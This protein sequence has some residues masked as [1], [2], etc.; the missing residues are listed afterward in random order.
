[1]SPTIPKEERER[2]ERVA[3]SSNGAMLEHWMREAH[4]ALDE[5]EV[6]RDEYREK[7]RHECSRGCPHWGH[8]TSNGVE[9]VCWHG[10]PDHFNRWLAEK[11]KIEERAEKAEADVAAVREQLAKASRAMNE[12]T[13]AADDAQRIATAAVKAAELIEVRTREKA[14]VDLAKGFV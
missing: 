3:V 10:V 7:W 2:R 6:E 1:M 11:G 13:K 4:A 14:L 12:K 8:H 5:A 9:R